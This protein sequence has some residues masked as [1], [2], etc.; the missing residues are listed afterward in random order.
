MAG[1]GVLLE[2]QQP[3]R[4]PAQIISKTSFLSSHG[5]GGGAFLERCFLCRR[6]LQQGKDIYMYRGDRGFC[7]EECRRRQMFMDEET[8]GRRNSI[9][10]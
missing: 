9:R 4:S 10:D 6:K 2:A 1:L 5:A 3:H 8:G 7:S